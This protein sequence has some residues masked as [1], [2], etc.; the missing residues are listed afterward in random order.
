MTA[1]NEIITVSSK[2]CRSINIS[3]DFNNV[4]ILKNYITSS[5]T[6]DVIRNIFENINQNGQSAFTLTGPY[7]A[8]KSSFALVLSSLFSENATLQK[9]AKKIV[10]RKNSTLV[11]KILKKNESWEIL[12][13]TGDLQTPDELLR[14]SLENKGYKTS[15]DLINDI[16]A[17]A[18]NKRGVLILFDEMG[19]CLENAVKQEG[20]I[21]FLQKLA[22]Y[23][24]RSDGK[25]IFVGILHQSFAEY[26][27]R[28]PRS[29]R[30][31]WTKIQGR[32][33]D[34]P[35]NVVGEEQIELIGRSINTDKNV[36]VIDN[37][38]LE[39]ISSNIEISKPIIN[40]EKFK[41]LLNECWPIHPLVICL[42]IQ[43][44]R[45]AFG[46]NQRSIFSF[47]NSGESKAFVDFIK[48]TEFSS[49][50]LYSIDDFFDYLSFNFEPTIL[51][52]PESKIW[53]IA[54][55]NLSRCISK[56][57]S[58]DHL[59]VFKTI[60]LIDMFSGNSGLTSTKEL[61]G[62]GLNLSNVEQ[63]LEDLTKWSVINFRNYTHSYSVFEGSDFNFELAM[64]EAYLNI[65]E[66]KLSKLSEIANFKPI[67]AKRHYHQFGSMR[68]MDFVFSPISSFNEFIKEEYSKRTTLGLFVILLPKNADEKILATSI[69]KTNYKEQIN[70]P[71]VV[72]IA[73][74]SILIRE[75]LKD[76]F[77]LEWIKE[78]C[79]ELDGDKVARIEIDTRISNI[80][81]LL[82]VQINQIIAVSEWYRDGKS[83]GVIGFSHL[84]RLVSDIAD[85]V[86][87]KSLIV[88]SELVNRTKPSGSANTVLNSLLKKMIL[89]NGLDNLDL[90]ESGPDKSLY[91]IL[92]KNSGLYEQ[93]TF[94]EPQDS[95]F[96]VLWHYTD[97][98][99][100]KSSKPVSI[101]ELYVLWANPPFGVKKGL[102]NFIALAYI[103]SHS[104]DLIVYKDNL[105]QVQM[106]DILLDYM[107]KAPNTISIKFVDDSSQNLLYVNA[108]KEVLNSF[109]D[110]VKFTENSS[111]L[112]IGQ[113]LVGFVYKLHPWVL[114]TKLLSKPVAK[115][116]DVLKT[117][118]DPN[119]AIIDDLK[120]VLVNENSS[121]SLIDQVKTN[122]TNILEELSNFFMKSMT[123][124]GKLMTLEL[125]V[126]L[127][128]PK[129]IEKLRD[130]A[131]N[132]KDVSGN[133]RLN[134]F[135]SRLS[136]FEENL[137]S[138]SGIV[139]LANSK[140]PND[141]I[142]LD[143]DNAKKELL[144]LCKEFKKTEI[145]T[146]IKNKKSNRQA[147]AF[148]TGIGGDA[149]IV[150]G[151]FDLLDSNI[152]KVDEVKSIIKSSLT[153][154]VDKNVLLAALTQM[155]IENIKEE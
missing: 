15:K 58:E 26:A 9:L 67:M 69:V 118:N 131:K 53:N 65:G 105:Y 106:T 47:L 1:L 10:G 16:N 81:S 32:F 90:E 150:E 35:I 31:E 74:N 128:T 152:G 51:A 71:F 139:A 99:L 62:E 94:V 30:N 60:S 38:I 124:I 91:N 103:L 102:F 64:S 61:L 59:T 49:E 122:L 135:A 5:S 116:R 11:N 96:K 146:K 147:V 142:D 43:V 40:K 79:N 87:P 149:E 21:Y 145:Y 37:E 84:S 119:K 130:R 52:S 17:I 45:K 112:E 82:E 18:E 75:Y 68:W 123:E 73:N 136:V 92:V 154:S 55:E 138:I 85:S 153:D 125:D 126:P 129:E 110:G 155:I 25:V 23:A 3:Q 72:T 143:I 101:D 111:L 86:Y 6:E 113:L 134:A 22:E 33:I 115:F 54:K 148:I 12:P 14:K 83:L 4:D 20:D 89:G 36:K 76:L 8:G 19:K 28:M 70:F 7:G 117:A 88:K 50:K 57:A 2:F 127:P 97:D 95:R 41:L 132:I 137:E 133:F 13:I 66:P 34:I 46:Q 120:K 100:K 77:A 114:K 27:K 109:F 93:N 39:S 48:N 56:G 80:V 63:I 78:N 140:S 141:W 108:I 104:K 98:Y 144:I 107:V 121:D 24:S 151:E 42:L 44:S 29:I